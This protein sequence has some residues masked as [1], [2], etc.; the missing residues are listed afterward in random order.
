MIL[1]R[2]SREYYGLEIVTDPPVDAWSASFDGEQT[3]VNGT[4]I[5][6]AWRWLVAGP[7]APDTTDAVVLTDDVLP[8]LR[9]LDSPEDIRHP[10]HE[11]IVLV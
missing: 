10:A 2:S 1:H 11:K 6:G 9:A 5:D 7:E 3:F 8:I 4:L